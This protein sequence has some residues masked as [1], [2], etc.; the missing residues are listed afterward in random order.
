MKLQHV[1]AAA[2]LAA[3]ASAG[4]QGLKPGLWEV[5]QKIQTQSGETERAMADMQKQM[6]AMPPEQRKQIEEMMARQGV[7]PG[8]GGDMSVKVCM[9][10]EM[11]ER[12]DMPMQQQRGDCKTTQQSRS[13]NTMKMAYTCATPPSSGEGEITYIG[14]EGY[15]MKMDVTTE[16]RGKPEKMNMQGSGKW[17]GADCGTVKPPPPAAKK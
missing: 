12:N 2:V 6:A 3:S 13:G 11:I 14:S 7:K 16:V 15:S 8:G 10:K 4:A 1:L 9:T 17:M 5:T